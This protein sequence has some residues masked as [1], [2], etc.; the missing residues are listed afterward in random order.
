VKALIKRLL[1]KAGYELR[2]KRPPA[3]PGPPSA[4]TPAPPRASMGRGLRWLRDKGLRFGTVLDV[5]ASN[6][7]WSAPCRDCFPEA[8]HVLF[9]PQPDHAAGLD[10]FVAHCRAGGG[11]PVIPVKKAV[12]AAPGTTFFDVT[13]LWGGA[14]ADGPGHNKIE[15]P[16]TT[17]DAVVAEL[18]LRGP[19]L[20]KLDTHGFEPSILRGAAAT[21]PQCAALVIEAYNYRISP[22]ALLFWELCALLAGQGFRPIDLVDVMHRPHDDSLWQM[23]LFFI[24]SSWSGFDCLAYD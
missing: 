22:E 17:I 10:A 1:A 2:R 5:G 24:R 9:E 15:V 13:Y 20:L 7:C 8:T 18:S 14:L 23:D 4:P 11:A 3:D 21:L 19:F 16:L 6:G 12:G